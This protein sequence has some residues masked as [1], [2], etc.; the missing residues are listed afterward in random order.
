MTTVFAASS[1]SGPERDFSRMEMASRTSCLD[2]VA[3]AAT[4]ATR[5]NSTPHSACLNVDIMG[6]DRESLCRKTG[7][8]QP[9]LPP[10]HFVAGAG[11]VAGAP[12][13]RGTE[14]RTLR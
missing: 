14:F 7:D 1:A 12:V 6:L 9:R 3:A 10:R 11:A 2:G 8:A 5:K 4:P 13:K